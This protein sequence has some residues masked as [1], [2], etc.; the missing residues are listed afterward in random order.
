MN[1]F[2]SLLLR[3]RSLV[4]ASLCL[5][6]VVPQSWAWGREGHRLTALVAEQ[7]LTPEARAQATALLNGGSLASV[8][9]WADEYRTDHPETAP[10]HYVDIPGSAAGQPELKFDRDRDC[11][12]SA[13]DP[14]SPWRDCVTDRILYFEGRLGD[15]S[16]PAA[17][18]AQ[19]LKFLVHLIGDVHQP[20]HAI[21]D[22]RGGNGIKVSF[23]GSPVCGTSQC[24]LHAVWDDAILEEQGLNDKKYT[25]RLVAEIQANHWERLA[26]GEPTGWANVSHH[27]ADNALAPQGALITRAYVGE[28]SKIVDAQLALGG[29][30]LAHVLN[31]ILTAPEGQG[32]VSKE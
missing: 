31:R 3:V 6:V 23:L 19:A 22:D 30:R 16:L 4:V 26:G 5:A 18:R 20:F 32:V 17:E 7:Y 2:P 10:W 21:G 12:V 11:P 14:K 8:A 27:Y 9:S 25:E 15:T 13:A 24:N 29:L 1:R 28:E